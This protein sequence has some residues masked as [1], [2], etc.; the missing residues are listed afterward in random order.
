MQATASHPVGDGRASTALAGDKP[1]L[2]AHGEASVVGSVLRRH[3][4][5]VGTQRTLVFGEDPVPLYEAEKRKNLELQPRQDC[6]LPRLTI[7]QM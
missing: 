2:S 6:L 3:S 4:R 5:E 7:N 1:M